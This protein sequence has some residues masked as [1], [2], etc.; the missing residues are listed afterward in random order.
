VK[1]CNL[2][3]NGWLGVRDYCH[4]HRGDAFARE[5]SFRWGSPLVFEVLL[6][7]TSLA[8]HTAPEFFGEPVVCPTCGG[9]GV[10]HASR[11]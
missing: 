5:P 8:W 4:S 6:R 11:H 10:I 7:V 1:R 2:P 9:T 3:A